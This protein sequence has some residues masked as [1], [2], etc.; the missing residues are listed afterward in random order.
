MQIDGS[1]R[2]GADVAELTAMLQDLGSAGWPPGI[3][4]IVR[5]GRPHPGAQM[6]FSAVPAAGVLSGGWMS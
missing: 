5:R 3:R 2:K 6:T 4:V 1:L